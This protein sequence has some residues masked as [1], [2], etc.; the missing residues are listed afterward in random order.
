VISA[1]IPRA[2]TACGRPPRTRSYL[3]TGFALATLIPGAPAAAQTVSEVQVTPETMTLGVGQKQAIFAAGFDQRGNLIPSAKITFWSSDTLIAQV[4]K[5]GTVLG[6][7][8]GLAKIEA[9]SQGKRASLAVLI[10]GTAR[11]APIASVLT[12][13]PAAV[14]LLP[15]ES[16]RISPQALREDGT[17]AAIGRVSWKSLKPEIATVD[18]AG[19][20]FGVGAGRTIVQATGNRLMA[21]LPVEVSQAD[22]VLSRNKISLGP[23]EAD[24]IRVLVP[25]QGNREVRGL[26]Q[27]R[28]SD[29]TVASVSPFG[30]VRAR[31][32]GQ[33]EII[34]SG[35]AQERRIAVSVHP[36]AEALVV[37]PHQGG[38]I[39]VPLHSTRQFT[40]VAEAADSSPIPEALVVWRL[41]DT[42]VASFDQGT[43]TLT[44][45]GLGTTTLT[46]MLAGITPAVWTVQVVP[47]EIVVDPS[48]VGLLVGQRTTLTTHLRD[49]QGGSASRS[50]GFRWASDRSE[51]ALVRDGVVDA[52]NPG[53]SVVS[54][55]APWGKSATADVYVVGDLL[56]VSNRGGAYGIY[57]MRVSGPAGLLPVLAD[58]ATN[59]QAALS[60]DRTR[61]AFSSNRATNYDLYVMDADG[62]NLQRLT[63]NPGNEG[64]PAWTPDGKRIVYTATTGAT[65]QIAII[66]VDGAENRQLT[67]GP[68]RNQSPAVSADGRTIAFVTTRD[69]NQEIY[70]MSLDG[71]N[72]RRLTKSSARDSNPRFFP[73]GDLL[74][75]TERGGKSKGSRVLRGGVAGTAGPLFETDEPI[76]SLALSRDGDRVAYIV[77]RLADASKGRVEF[78]LFLQSTAPGSQPVAVPIRPGEQILNP[79]F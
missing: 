51:V 20:V 63:S 13:E 75:V 46:A 36:L 22:F 25:S 68:S 44:P 17:P 37:S 27:W 14:T 33:A 60:P 30:V 49:D 16:V 72:Q 58:S 31:A 53:H 42:A 15:G 55:T 3:L 67:M 54:A 19:V 8:P 26:V 69:G 38:I 56:L 79:S 2:R 43:G 32:A 64:E 29:S 5:D 34:A 66:S 61:V 70:T 73:S 24:T 50:A 78:N 11:G 12:L 62:R 6:V 23:E 52:L 1:P 45:K 39:K 71:S 48:R 57:Q 9:R 4:R 41:S 47:G 18:S 10:T 7:S 35:P 40:A 59:I 28:S 65:T 74:Y 76:A 21:T 77:G